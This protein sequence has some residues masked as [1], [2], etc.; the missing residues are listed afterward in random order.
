MNRIPIAHCLYNSIGI[1]RDAMAMKQNKVCSYSVAKT[2]ALRNAEQT[3]V[4]G[5]VWKV[6]SGERS[7]SFT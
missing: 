2:A 1:Q 6:I 5:D 7:W 3:V 4:D